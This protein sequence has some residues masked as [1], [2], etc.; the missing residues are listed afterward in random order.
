MIFFALCFAFE[1]IFTK[2]KDFIREASKKCFFFANIEKTYQKSTL[3]TDNIIL[4]D[5]DYM[6][7]LA[8]KRKSMLYEYLKLR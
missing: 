3:P 4:K 6:T 8:S 5:F 2:A 7:S 1:N